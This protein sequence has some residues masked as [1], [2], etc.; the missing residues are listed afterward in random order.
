MPNTFILLPLPDPSIIIYSGTNIRFENGSKTDATAQHT[1]LK[2]QIVGWY[3]KP[4]NI[5]DAICT[6]RN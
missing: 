5:L 6:H 3:I 1:C 4:I 2:L